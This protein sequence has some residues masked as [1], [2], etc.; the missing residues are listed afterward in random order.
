MIKT[1]L[2]SLVLTIFFEVAVALLFERSK[3]FLLSVLLVNMV[4]HTIFNFIL[5]VLADVFSHEINLSGI[6]IFE[7]V[8]VAVEYCLLVYAGFSK[9]K[10][11]YFSFMANAFSLSVGL[12]LIKIGLLPGA[13]IF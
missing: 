3:L 4:T 13:W 10:M 12:L 9:T 7:L 2:L 8:I 11:L 6:L 5:F 1:Y